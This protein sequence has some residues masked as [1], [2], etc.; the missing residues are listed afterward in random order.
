MSP[1]HLPSIV[2]LEQVGLK[3]TIGSNFLLQDISFTI[4]PGDK[5]AIVGASGAGKTSLLRLLN[6][7]VSPDL[8]T[9]YFQ[10]QPRQKLTSIQ[11][12]RRV[13]LVAQEPKLLGMNTLEA[14]SYPLHLQKLAETEIRHRIETWMD[15]LRISP[16]WL[17]KTELQLSL[18]QRQLIAIARALVMNPQVLL[19]DEPT[20]ALDVGI[21]NHLL[22]VLEDLNQKQNLT[23]I[24][25]NHQLELIKNF[26]DRILYL[27]AGRL[28]EDI[29]ATEADWL[30]LRQK[31]LQLQAAQEQEWL[32]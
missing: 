14:L 1:H 25:V 2:R 29:G 27:N 12:R 18:G 4:Q 24:M 6:R 3:A 10:E 28:E 15:R 16:E 11:L 17:N 23:I 31:L 9:V 13:V 30:R 22:N 19:L 5:I 20:S 21:A 8:G 32:E 26:C 7:L